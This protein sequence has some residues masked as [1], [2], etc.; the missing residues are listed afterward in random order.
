MTIHRKLCSSPAAS[1]PH[2]HN[3]VTAVRHR[4]NTSWSSMTH[5]KRWTAA[6]FQKEMDTSSSFTATGCLSCPSSDTQQASSPIGRWL[7]QSQQHRC[8][9]TM[10]TGR[11]ERSESCKIQVGLLGH[12]SPRFPGYA[13]FFA[14]ASRH[15][16]MC[17]GN[18]PH[19][20]IRRRCFWCSH[21]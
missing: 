19:I 12:S 8:T 6:S 15:L 3:E 10:V 18:K 11:R 2:N 1:A 13:K 7:A 21:H 5:T 14:G 20:K 4:Q 17:S 16:K 9:P